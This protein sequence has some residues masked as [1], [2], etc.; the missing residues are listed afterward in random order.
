[1]KTIFPAP[2]VEGD[3]IAIISPAGI[4]KPEFVAGEVE[5]LSQ[6]G[7]RPVVM[8]HA[9]GPACGSYAASEKDRLADFLTAWNDPEIKAVLCSRGGYG[10]VALIGAIPPSMLR[11]NAKWLAGFSDISALH[12]MLS[13]AGIASV[14][15]VMARHISSFPVSDPSTV[16]LL[17]C[18]GTEEEITYTAPHHLFDMNGETS[19]RLIGG[20]LAVI[21]GLAS[22]AFDLFSPSA[23]QDC[24]L[25]IE[26][27]SEAIYAVER[28]LWRLRLAGTL[29]KIAGLLVGRFTEVSADRNFPD[30]ETMIHNRLLDW[31]LEG[32]P[33][34][35]GIPFGHIDHNLALIEGSMA[36]LRVNGDG[37]VLTMKKSDI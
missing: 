28:M 4:V 19:G 30:V 29:D 2:V 18:I 35:F 21:N 25:F 36:S 27:I 14:H 22:T 1:M 37:T 20:N 7:F 23:A 13:H 11:A 5:K 3:K 10:A 12:A 26:D 17:R 32:I 34:S 8:P 9:L 16:S 15:G 33:V 6:C 31:G 24:I